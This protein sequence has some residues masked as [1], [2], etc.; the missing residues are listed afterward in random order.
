MDAGEKLS[1]RSVREIVEA[2]VELEAIVRDLAAIEPLVTKGE[3][4]HGEWEQCG[5]C[6]AVNRWVG[7]NVKHDQSCVWWTAAAWVL[8]HP[9]TD[10]G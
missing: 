4:V 7:D 5:I 6:G 10:R 9:E 3:S 2:G 1:P 8:D